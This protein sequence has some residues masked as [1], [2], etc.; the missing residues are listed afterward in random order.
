M[1][2][3]NLRFTWICPSLWK[4]QEAKVKNT[5]F[6]YNNQYIPLRDFHY[7]IVQNSNYHRW[8]TNITEW[9]CEAVI[10]QLLPTLHSI[11]WFVDEVSLPPSSSSR[12]LNKREFIRGLW[13]IKPRYKIWKIWKGKMQALGITNNISTRAQ[14]LH[15]WCK[16]QTLP[17]WQKN[18]LYT[19]SIFIWRWDN[20]IEIIYDFKIIVSSFNKPILCT[21]YFSAIFST[22]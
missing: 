6:F 19:K 11:T 9:N 17:Q 18:P 22:Q 8:F 21:V 7:I 20:K 16:L 13:R 5:I 3:H 2:P 14:H 4:V 1:T 12:R 15:L 10:Q